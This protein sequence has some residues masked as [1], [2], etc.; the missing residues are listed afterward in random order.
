M[1]A[2]S[3]AETAVAVEVKVEDEVEVEVVFDGGGEE[4]A[5]PPAGR[6]RSACGSWLSLSESLAS[7]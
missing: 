1:I 3:S 6:K 5:A 7:P 2:V 4:A